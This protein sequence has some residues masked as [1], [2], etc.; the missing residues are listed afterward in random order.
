M[1][2]QGRMNNTGSEIRIAYDLAM[3]TVIKDTSE[4]LLKRYKKNVYIMRLGFDPQR[5]KDTL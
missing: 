2:A 5:P 1:L 4:L 3:T